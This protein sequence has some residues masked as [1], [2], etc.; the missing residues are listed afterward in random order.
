MENSVVS[1]GA[2]SHSSMYS[3]IALGHDDERPGRPVDDAGGAEVVVSDPGRLDLALG[4][5][6][7]QSERA[8]SDSNLADRQAGAS[9]GMDAHALF[10]RD[11][12]DPGRRYV[13]FN[14]FAC[15]H[16]SDPFSSVSVSVAIRGRRWFS[17]VSSRQLG[18]SGRDGVLLAGRERFVDLF[19]TD[20]RCHLL[21]RCSGMTIPV[22]LVK[23][24]WRALAYSMYSASRLGSSLGRSG[25]HSGSQRGVMP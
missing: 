3:R 8:V 23:R 16:Q 21:S 9:G 20:G 18:E 13:A 1:N 19:A 14:R 17:R 15:R 22:S 12:A 10:P 5:Q 2:M 7:D 24:A 6:L 4:D 25:A 11:V